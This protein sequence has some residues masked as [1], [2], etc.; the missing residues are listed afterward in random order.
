MR[1]YPVTRFGIE[2]LQAAELP[3]LQIAPGSV[4]I[5]VY[6]VSLNY[7]DSWS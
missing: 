5:K 2:Y 4:L 7:R 1:A 3:E 6:A